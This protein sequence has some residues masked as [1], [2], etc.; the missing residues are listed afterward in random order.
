MQLLDFQTAL[1]HV[2]ASVAQGDLG[3][4]ED[5]DKQFGCHI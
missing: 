1:K 5:W 2:K 3:H 4:Y